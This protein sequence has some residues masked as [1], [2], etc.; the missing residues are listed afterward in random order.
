MALGIHTECSAVQMNRHWCTS[1]GAL[2]AQ[3]GGFEPF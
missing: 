2:V 3:A 1:R